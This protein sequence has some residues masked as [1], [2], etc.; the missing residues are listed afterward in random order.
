MESL[1]QGIPARIDKS[2]MKNLSG[3]VQGQILGALRYLSLIDDQGIVTESLGRLVKSQRPERQQLL[4][5][6]LKSSYPFLFDE[7][8]LTTATSALLNME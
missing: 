3:A 7:F 8:D 1:Q 6:I 2:L 5:T 4:Q